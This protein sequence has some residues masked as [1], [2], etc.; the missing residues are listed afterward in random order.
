M[1]LA[2]RKG[3]WF[4]AAFAAHI[5]G[6]NLSINKRPCHDAEK[7]HLWNQ[8]IF[9]WRHAPIEGVTF[10]PTLRYRGIPVLV[11]H[12]WHPD[13][14]EPLLSVLMAQRPYRSPD[15]PYEAVRQRWEQLISEGWEDG[16]RDGMA[17]YV[18]VEDPELEK[19]EGPPPEGAF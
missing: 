17:G 7:F 8:R 15:E 13:S 14:E 19:I 4:L 10:Y 5:N 2:R 12:G 16:G 3:E 6:C 9:V 18:H 11:F 1:I